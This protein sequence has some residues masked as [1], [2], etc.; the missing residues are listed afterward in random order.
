MNRRQRAA[1]SQAE[2]VKKCKL[3]GPLMKGYRAYREGHLRN[4]NP[5][6]RI[7]NRGVWFEGWDMGQEKANE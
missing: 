4:T 7:K 5:Y 2:T 3:Y 6:H 1:I